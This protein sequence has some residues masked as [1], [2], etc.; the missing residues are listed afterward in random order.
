MTVPDGR[1]AT[2]A[3]ISG[4]FLNMTGTGIWVTARVLFLV[5]VT[6]LSSVE[7]A[8][9]LLAAGLL[10]TAMSLLFGRLA[11]RF[12][13]RDVTIVFLLLEGVAAAAFSIVG[14][15]LSFLIIVCLAASFAWLCASASGAMLAR[16]FPGSRVRV[17]SLMQAAGNVGL[18]TGAALA[19]L[20]LTANNLAVYRWLALANGAT[21]WLAALAAAVLP[22]V[23]A[24]NSPGAQARWRA[25]RDRRYV[26]VAAVN[27]L[28]SV[29]ASL[30][31][32][33]LPLWVLHAT[34]A[35]LWVV[36]ASL[37]A[38]TALVGVFQVRAARRIRGINSALIAVRD[39]GLVIGISCALFAFAD[40]APVGVAI[41]MI[42]TSAVA[43]TVGEMWHSAG[44]YGLSFDLAPEDGHGEYQALYG[45][46]A[47]VGQA[48]SPA[49]LMV[50]TVDGGTSGWLLL[51]FGFVAVGW[52]GQRMLYRQV[53][54]DQADTE[55]FMTPAI[56]S[57]RVASTQRER[58]RRLELLLGMESTDSGTPL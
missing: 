40:H 10:G 24:L 56:T 43:Y 9:G 12:V 36:G 27:M 50:A 48:F 30:L 26:S 25:L 35:P 38:N 52:L 34:S 23:P 11:D 53:A 54:A 20:A 18:G 1:R 49:L 22:R 51:G 7:I 8:E 32:V 3:L 13:A 42:L 31:T 29:H 4:Y 6:G 46:F 17:R 21:F 5:R 19:T 28:M 37:V 41:A 15:F 58:E 44:S 45:A 2:K 39:A 57:L 14:S 16:T 33:A 47:S 55:A